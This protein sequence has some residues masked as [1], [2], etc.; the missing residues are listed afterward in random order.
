MHK[1]VSWFQNV[2]SVT[3]ASG[4]PKANG[5]PLGTI[6]L[7]K[8]PGVPDRGLMEQGTGRCSRGRAFGASRAGGA[9][10]YRA[11]GT[12]VETMGHGAHGAS[13]GP[14]S[15]ANGVPWNK[16]GTR[17]KDNGP[18]DLG[19]LNKESMGLLRIP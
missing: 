8:L 1:Y 2:S 12:T 13:W 14:R 7:L 19:A 5:A 10:K 3:R 6:M 16:Q 11:N 15:R 17:S 4:P 18:L 9:P